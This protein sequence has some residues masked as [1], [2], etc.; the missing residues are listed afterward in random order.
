LVHIE[1]PLI[2]EPQNNVIKTE[3]AKAKQRVF[4][5]Q[6][7]ISNENVIKEK[8]RTKLRKNEI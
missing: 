3:K 7:D 5:K 1:T 4:L 2:E 6:N 8:R